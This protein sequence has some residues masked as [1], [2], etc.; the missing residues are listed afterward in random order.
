[1][2]Q[3]KLAKTL[4]L[5]K[6]CKQARKRPCVRI[7]W[8][9]QLCLCCSTLVEFTSLPS[10][11]SFSVRLWIY[12]CLLSSTLIPLVFSFDRSI[13]EKSLV[14]ILVCHLLSH[15]PSLTRVS[16]SQEKSGPKVGGES[17][18]VRG[19]E[20]AKFLNSLQSTKTNG[21]LPKYL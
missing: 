14:Q 1:M 20:Y 9:A 4:S 15:C 21:I 7:A 2:L 11:S 8:I 16:F 3:R 17:L 6:N 10:V 5:D 19:P 18:M 13:R 12:S